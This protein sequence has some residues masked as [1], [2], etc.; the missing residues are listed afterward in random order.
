MFIC[1]Q[2]L[3]LSRDSGTQMKVVLIK[4]AWLLNIEQSRCICRRNFIV[5]FL[6]LLW[7]TDTAYKCQP[8]VLIRIGID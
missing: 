2:T 7:T 3:I 4:C 8:M 6:L 5:T 1:K